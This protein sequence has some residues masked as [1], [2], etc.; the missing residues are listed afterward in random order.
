MCDTHTIDNENRMVSFPSS[1]NRRSSEAALTR[2]DSEAFGSEETVLAMMGDSTVETRTIMSNAVSTLTDPIIPMEPDCEPAE[3]SPTNNN[4]ISKL[5]DNS[6]LLWSDDPEKEYF[7][8]MLQK[9]QEDR[10][11]KGKPSED[12][13]IGKSTVEEIKMH[14]SGSQFEEEEIIFEDMELDLEDQEDDDDE[15]QKMILEPP[16]IADM[17]EHLL[18]QE[19]DAPKS[20][21]SPPSIVDLHSVHHAVSTIGDFSHTAEKKPL[22]LPNREEPVPV[23]PRHPDAIYVAGSAAEEKATQQ[24]TEEG[25]SRNKEC[26][27][28]LAVASSV[29]CGMAIAA[30]AIAIYMTTMS[31]GDGGNDVPSAVSSG[32][33][34]PSTNGSQPLLQDLVPSSSPQPLQS[35]V[36]TSAP[37]GVLPQTTN[38]PT[39]TGSTG[40]ITGDTATNDL[41]PS[42]GPQPL[43]SLMPTSNPSFILPQATNAPTYTVSTGSFMGDTETNDLVP[44]SGPQLLQNLVPTSAPTFLLSGTTHTPT[45]S[46][47]VD[48]GTEWE[49]LGI[50]ASPVSMFSAPSTPPTSS[51]TSTSAAPI[52]APAV[53]PLTSIV[54]FAE[55][56]AGTSAAPSATSTTSTLTQ[57]PINLPSSSP[58]SVR[59]AADPTPAP[60]TGPPPLKPPTE[61]PSSSK[62]TQLPTSL[63]PTRRPTTARPTS[64]PPTRRPTLKP[65]SLLGECEGALLLRIFSSFFM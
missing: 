4:N 43:Q 32:Q 14:T 34:D 3:T 2:L 5:E 64:R 37:S 11:R 28:Y 54:V 33:N 23:P 17:D 20:S 8:Y 36:P 24:P 41:V 42:S 30:A 31:S 44:T 49:A 16:S 45:D 7:D 1:S 6:V 26:L 65:T 48:S 39:Y 10:A 18:N 38:N 46:G 27:F 62:P 25:R 47:F 59:P 40:S 22:N 12:S 9:E 61:L 63:I 60:I 55:A 51:V 13:L 53:P 56:E 58:P 50:A 35:L 57:T 19:S 29:L 15:G 21:L 52:Q